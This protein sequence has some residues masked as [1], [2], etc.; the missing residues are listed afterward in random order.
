MSE[1]VENNNEIEVL[2]EKENEDDSN[3]VYESS[4]SS[5]FKRIYS[6]RVFTSIDPSDQI[7][8]DFFDEYIDSVKMVGNKV[9]YDDNIFYLKRE[10]KVSVILEKEEALE[11]AQRLINSYGDN[12][13]LEGEEE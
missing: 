3:Y 2:E 8:L 9:A 7:S 13:E 10:L 5:D 6:N 11:L 4:E 1:K 12:E